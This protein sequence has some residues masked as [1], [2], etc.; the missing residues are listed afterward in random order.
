MLGIR[1]AITKTL[2]DQAL[3]LAKHRGRNQVCTVSED[4]IPTLIAEGG[5]QKLKEAMKKDIRMGPTPETAKDENAPEFDVEM[6]KEKGLLGVLAQLVRD[7][8][9]RSAYGPDRSSRAYAYANRVAQTLRL[10]KD[11]T[12]VVSLA[13][14]LCNL[15]KMVV[16]AETLQKA[17]PLTEEDRIYIN[18]VP[19]AGAKFLEPAKILA[20]ISPIIEAYHEH[21]DGSGYP[22][23]IK[24]DV[25]P[26]EARIVS[27]VDAYTAM[28]SD[29]PY[30]PAYSHEE[31]MRLIQEGSG[32]EWDPRLVKIF[33][34]FLKAERQ[35]AEKAEREAGK[36]GDSP[37]DTSQ[38]NGRVTSENSA[39]VAEVGAED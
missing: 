37:S 16:P 15:G 22:N 8:E 5:E 9:H 10:T 13:A 31:A 25:I 23:G 27:L 28:T 11:H 19:H 33:L 6:I 30:R 36:N 20:K 3:F 32:K 35:Q 14:V 18:Q 39:V 2:A 17:D 24:G 1:Y 21:F 38:S 29:R 4:L 12:E 7:V 34:S 26:I